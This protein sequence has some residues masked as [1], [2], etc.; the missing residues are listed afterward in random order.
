MTG[1]QGCTGVKEAPV[2]RD[3]DVGA[4][5]EPKKNSS[6]RLQKQVEKGQVK[7]KRTDF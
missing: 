6:R 3:L 2:A 7:A 1:K 5:P 4:L